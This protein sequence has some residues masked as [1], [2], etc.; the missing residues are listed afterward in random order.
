[1]REDVLASDKLAFDPTAEFCWDALVPRVHGPGARSVVD[2]GRLVAVPAG[3]DNSAPS[4]LPAQRMEYT[5]PPG[6]SIAGSRTAYCHDLSGVL[7]VS[8]APRGFTEARLPVGMQI[9]APRHQHDLTLA[10]AAA[11]RVALRVHLA[12]PSRIDIRST[13]P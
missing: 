8:A 1:M 4:L 6:G 10:A 2:L 5:A 3:R 7:P 12:R 11:W 13:V 9:V